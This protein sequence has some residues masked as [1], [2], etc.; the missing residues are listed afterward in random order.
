M[1]GIEKKLHC[2]FFIFGFTT[3]AFAQNVDKLHNKGINA[4]NNFD[5]LHRNGQLNDTIYI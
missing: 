2:W 3:I 1:C 5:N 4:F